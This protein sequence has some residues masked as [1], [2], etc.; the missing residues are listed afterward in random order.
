MKRL[1]I[2]FFVLIPVIFLSPSAHSVDMCKYWYESFL[3]ATG[4]GADE[5]MRSWAPK[6][7][8]KA[9]EKCHGN[10]KMMKKIAQAKKRFR[11]NPDGIGLGTRSGG[12]K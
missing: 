12:N 3:V 5:D 9:E 8:A 11:E 2:P 7:L 1:T 4:E 6:F 10:K